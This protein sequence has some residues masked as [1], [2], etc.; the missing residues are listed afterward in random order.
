MRSDN[1]AKQLIQLIQS[2]EIPIGDRLPSMRRL[3]TK[4][5]VSANT[6]QVALKELEVLRMIERS[7]RRRPVVSSSSPLLNYPVEK[8]A[9]QIAIIVPIQPGPSGM[10][11]WRSPW[12]SQII[13][14]MEHALFDSGY[15][16]GLVFASSEG[17]NTPFHARLDMLESSLAGCICFSSPATTLLLEELDRRKLPWV[18]IG[19][20]AEGCNHN[21]V[22][23]D[24]FQANRQMGNVFVECGFERVALLVHQL[25]GFV[26]AITKATGF[27]QGYLE[28]GASTE[29]I[30]VVSCP[31]PD[32]ADS[33]NIVQKLL[34]ESYRPQAIL[35]QGDYLAIGAMRAIQDAGLR[36][37]EDISVVGTTGLPGSRSTNPPLTV[38]E[39][40]MIEIGQTAVKL[41]HEMIS[42]GH[43]KCPPQWIPCRAVFRESLKIPESVRL[44]LNIQAGTAG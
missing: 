26:S 20:P 7:P 40:P 2:E 41:L 35:A 10:D 5:H 32:Q 8:K 44:S 39:Q 30:R 18:A 11:E 9:K 31:S 34:T 37:P 13:H 22:A 14:A 29:G 19:Q 25:N 33:Y 24:N 16:M 36:I 21:F 6:V 1:L 43:P 28:K 27:F 23:A 38:I 12:T 3:A 15:T 17:A 42:E 4:F